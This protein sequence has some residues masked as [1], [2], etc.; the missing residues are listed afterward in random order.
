MLMSS[1]AK[2][3][4]LVPCLWRKDV[5]IACFSKNVHF[6]TAASIFYCRRWLLRSHVCFQSLVAVKNRSLVA[7]RGRPWW[8]GILNQSLVAV[9]CFAAL[10]H[11]LDVAL[12]ISFWLSLVGFFTLSPRGRC[13]TRCLLSMWFLHIH[14]KHRNADVHKVYVNF[15]LLCR[16]SLFLLMSWLKFSCLYPFK[17]MKQRGLEQLFSLLSHIWGLFDSVTMG[18]TY[19]FW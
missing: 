4:W 12:M 11:I 18:K 3:M 9:S 7:V 19:G 13:A 5:P 15:F 17:W 8:Q 1:H 14:W 10:A 16:I 6:C 2:C